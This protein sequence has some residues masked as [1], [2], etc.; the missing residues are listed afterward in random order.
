M[1]KAI[2][3]RKEA[4]RTYRKARKR[5]DAPENIL[6]MWNEYKEKKEKAKKL[7]HEKRVKS[8]KTLENI[9]GKGKD[10]AKKFWRYIR[11]KRKQKIK[12]HLSL[13]QKET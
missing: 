7:A 13:A 1:Q 6:A 10:S 5:E 11:G 4:C 3:E 9:I 8:N 12:Q 2:R